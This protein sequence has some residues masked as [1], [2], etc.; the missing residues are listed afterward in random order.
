MK[1]KSK[2]FLVL[3][4]YQKASLNDNDKQRQQSQ[5]SKC[6]DTGRQ[7]KRSSN[8]INTYLGCMKGPQSAAESH[9][10]VSCEPD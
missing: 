8:T 5:V 2:H 1:E 9:C 6:L 4:K 7:T 3:L 10:Q